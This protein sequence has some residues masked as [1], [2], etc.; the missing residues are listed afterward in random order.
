MNCNVSYHAAERY[1][2]IFNIENPNE[3]S[4]LLINHVK[5]A[6]PMTDIELLVVRKSKK[7]GYKTQDHQG[8]RH[9]IDR[10]SYTV[11]VVL[12]QITENNKIQR[13]VLTC[14]K[15]IYLKQIPSIKFSCEDELFKKNYKD[16]A[17]IEEKQHII[18]IFQEACEIQSPMQWGVALMLLEEAG[19]LVFFQN[20][21]MTL[22]KSLFPTGYI[23]SRKISPIKLKRL[24]EEHIHFYSWRKKYEWCFK[25]FGIKRE[26]DIFN[27]EKI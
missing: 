10:K 23:I 15:A 20:K 13:V 14:Y 26:F 9:L 5:Y 2:K 12:D 27:F 8:A 22:T 17:C 6:E 1:S 18:G 4:D 19:Y 16:E 25:D 24:R 3:A 7:R 11:F 21:K